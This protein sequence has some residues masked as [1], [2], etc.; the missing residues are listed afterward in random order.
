[1]VSCCTLKSKLSSSFKKLLLNEPKNIFAQRN[2]GVF[3]LGASCLKIGGELSGANWPGGELSGY[4]QVCS[5]DK[6]G[7]SGVNL[8]FSPAILHRRH[9]HKHIEQSG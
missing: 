4:Q 1:M 5:F 6:I 2:T 9:K 7:V 3:I 8:P